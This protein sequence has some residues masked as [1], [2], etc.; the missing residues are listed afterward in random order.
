MEAI[1]RTVS[2]FIG[3]GVLLYGVIALGMAHETAGATVV[4]EISAICWA[5]LGTQFLRLAKK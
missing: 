4:H 5:I 3:V 2:A 1:L